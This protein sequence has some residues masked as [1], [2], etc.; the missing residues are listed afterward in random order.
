MLDRN[1]N[2]NS[3]LNTRNVRGQGEK[4]DKNRKTNI[5]LVIVVVVL[6][7][8]CLFFGGRYIWA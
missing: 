8:L 3:F 7:I 4:R 5:F 2:Q 6:G 1:E